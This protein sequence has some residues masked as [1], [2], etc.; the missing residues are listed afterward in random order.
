VARPTREAD[1]ANGHEI[2]LILLWS[3]LKEH[4]RFILGVA[5]LIWVAVM[6]QTLLI[7]MEFQSTGR[8]YLGELE[9]RPAPGGENGIDLLGASEGD[10]A[11]EIEILRSRSIVSEAVAKSGLNASI[12][13]ASWAPPRFWRWLLSK[14]DPRL[15]EGA[16]G[17]LTVDHA[18]LPAVERE[19]LA[20]AVRFK[21]EREYEV[22]LE[23]QPLA[24]GTLGVPVETARGSF[25]LRAGSVS[26]PRTDAQ[27][28][29][30]IIPFEDVVDGAIMSLNV[31][32]PKVGPGSS[33]S[34]KVVTLEFPDQSPQHAAAFLRELMDAYLSQRQSW[35][36]ENATAAESFVSSQLQS[37]RDSL[38]HTEQRLADYRSN[39]V[40]VLDNEAKAL[41]EQVGKYEE[42]RV[43]ARLQVAALSDIKR[44]LKQPNPPVEAYLLGEAHDTVLEGLGRSLAEARKQLVELEG[45]FHD[46]APDVRNQKAQVDAQL[47]TVRN[48]VTSRLA[49]AQENLSELNGVIGQ[50]EDK[51]RSV[52]GAE[53]GL[54]QL[55]RESDVYSKLYSNLLE[56]KQQAAILKASTVS[57]NRILDLPDVPRRE[58]SPRLGMRLASGVLGLL[59]GA[60][61]VLMR[62]VFASTVQSEADIRTIIANIPVLAQ[63][64]RW[65]KQGQRSAGQIAPAFDTLALDAT[66]PFTEAFRT[67]RTGVYQAG[68]DRTGQVLLVTSPAPGDGKTTTALCLAAMLA[69]DG[70]WVLTVDADLRKPSHHI[71][72]G[73]H[74]EHGLRGILSGQC[75]WRDAVRPVALPSGEFYSIGAGKMAPAEL[76]SSE[77]MAR[78]LIEARAR[79]DFILLDAPSFPLVADPL[80][81]APHAD[82]VL[83]VMRLDHTPGKLAAEH[84]KRLPEVA[85]GFGVVINGG[86]AP[87][88]YGYGYG[89]SYPPAPRR[90]WIARLRRPR[91]G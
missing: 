34:V 42:Q 69:A 77:R 54:A 43:E 9:S 61:L 13:P 3:A 88:A 46:T 33:E 76:I 80:V 28:D 21:S 87:A 24:Q 25:T 18:S 50:F 53:L 20:F 19:A 26:R 17:E 30:V 68:R 57:K 14:R 10:V 32:A 38:D 91:L 83:S 52:P 12:A 86:S 74:E 82:A 65:N 8:L 36:T 6:T 31:T 4:K 59:L 66:S 16:S 67:V 2:D 70:K 63:V 45:R 81:L 75:Q 79:Y 90:S 49:R 55:A 78:F 58:S 47:D 64:P 29:L 15:L 23:G 84:V 71:L 40:V 72:T 89:S 35:K 7:R 44:V 27:Y 85:H 48:Y 1:A 56:R 62:R 51:L 39:A 37:M 11:S 5:A 73:H 22:L 41:I 60:L